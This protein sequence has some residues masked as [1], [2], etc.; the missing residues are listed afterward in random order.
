MSVRR[1]ESSRKRG[2]RRFN[3]AKIPLLCVA[4]LMFEGRE[5]EMEREKGNGERKFSLNVKEN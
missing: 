1:D 2:S 3:A 4:A 5:R